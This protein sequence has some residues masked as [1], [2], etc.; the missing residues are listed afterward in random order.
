MWK[1]FGTVGSSGLPWMVC[2]GIG[3]WALAGCNDAGDSSMSGGYEKEGPAVV[4]G[5]EAEDIRAQSAPEAEAETDVSGEAAGADAGG[6]GEADVARADAGGAGEEEDAAGTGER[7]L[8][9]RERMLAEGQRRASQQS[10]REVSE[11]EGPRASFTVRP[12]Q[13]WADLTYFRFDASLSSDDWDLSGQLEKRW[14]FDGDG[15]WDSEIT[16]R[17]RVSHRYGEPGTYRP[18]LWVR[19]TGGLVDSI[20]GDPIVVNPA[21][22]PPDFAMVDHNPHS[23]TKGQTLRL[24]EQRGHPVL[25]W[26]TAPSK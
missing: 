4:A 6:A 21:C 5:G 24:S 19:D 11:N 14:D 1:A 10:Q 17:G 12:L 20:T 26:F 25:L 2:L 23:P 9:R 18:R 8:T 7:M 15:T 22:P 3:L 16:G 13:G